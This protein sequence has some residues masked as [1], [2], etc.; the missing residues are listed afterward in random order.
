[1]VADSAAADNT[2]SFPDSASVSKLIVPKDGA[3][4][5]EFVSPDEILLRAP[6]STQCRTRARWTF[7]IPL[8]LTKAKGIEFEIY[9]ED[10]S[11]FNGYSI[12]MN[13]GTG[14]YTGRYLP[15]IEGQW[16]KVTVLKQDFPRNEGNVAGWG[17]IKYF[18]IAMWKGVRRDSYIKFRNFK[19]IGC[20]P[21]VLVVR[22]DWSLSKNMNATDR[23]NR[24]PENSSEMLDGLLAMGVNATEISDLEIDE[25]ILK[26]TSVVVFPWNPRLPPAAIKALRK[27]S[28]RG[29]KFFAFYSVP[30]GLNDLFEVKTSFFLV[31]KDAGAPFAG[32]IQKVGSGIQGQPDFVH[33]DDTCMSNVKLSQNCRS[34]A[35]WV[36]PDGKP[37]GVPALVKTPCG[38]YFGHTWGGPLR[39]SRALMRAVLADMVPSM[40]PM[41]EESEK[42]YIQSEISEA[43]WVASQKSR[44]G[45]LRSISCHSAQGPDGYSWDESIRLIKENGLNCI[46]P[47]V[48][49][50]DRI[51]EEETKE[52]VEACR[53]YGVK[54]ALWKVC[55]RPY[56]DFKGKLPGRTQVKYSGAP[57]DRWMCPSDPKNVA[58]EVEMSLK[59]AKMGAD[60]LS[61]DYVRYP[62]G[63]SC[64][65]AGCRELF[66]KK[67][68]KVKNWPGDLRRN[69]DLAEKW[70]QFRC[71]NITAFVRE[72]SRRVRAECPGVKIKVS[73]FHQTDTV[74]E[75]IGQDWVNW[76]KDGLVDIIGP[77]NY[78]CGPSPLA[79][80]GLLKQQLEAIK[81]SDVVIMPGI[82]LS[83]WPR[84]GHDAKRICEQI[85]VIRGM[86]LNHYG[87]FELRS[88]AIGLLPMLKKGIMGK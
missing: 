62:D 82:G 76:C 71:D 59:L 19:V 11:P 30:E 53:K 45:E 1:M 57:A 29:G 28:A 42:A 47:N 34:I 87:I 73:V 44:K 49:W 39:D 15:Y 51:F 67:H 33:R 86:G 4:A 40:R 88:R 64:F 14:C 17:K 41:L 16:H 37:I 3:P 60:I 31:R 78:Y 58:S 54:N 22:G 80:K 55:W 36:L 72:V 9:S 27:F 8:D 10:Y 65:C 23:S 2:I 70:T 63:D 74:R 32:G 75:D 13:S 7:Q 66:E 56:R 20:E 61:L 69:K 68:G 77:M 21:D 79:Y 18:S 52:C 43:K 48:A 12:Y 81:G 83:V 24:Y 38:Y 50:A 6:F 46:S 5:A 35:Q 25:S 85:N 26:G 84:D